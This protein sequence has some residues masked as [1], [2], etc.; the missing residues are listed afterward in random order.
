MALSDYSIGPQISTS[1]WFAFTSL[2]KTHF[3]MHISSFLYKTAFI[4]NSSRTVKGIL[5]RRKIHTNINFLCL[6]SIHGK[7]MVCILK[8]SVWILFKKLRFV[9]ILKDF[10]WQCEKLYSHAWVCQICGITILSRFHTRCQSRH[11]SVTRFLKLSHN[12]K[13]IKFSQLLKVRAEGADHPRPLQSG[14]LWPS[15]MYVFYMSRQRFIHF[16]FRFITCCT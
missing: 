6:P 1:F 3:Q 8:I 15:F 12:N 4:K 5:I 7:V 14:F 11:W 9:C 2:T 13:A 10:P 16:I